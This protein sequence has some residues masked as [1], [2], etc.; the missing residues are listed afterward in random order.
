MRRKI[1]S[2]I[3]SRRS[4]SSL[5]IQNGPCTRRSSARC[6]RG[7]CKLASQAMP[8][9][10]AVFP[11][12]LTAVLSKSSCGLAASARQEPIDRPWR[13]RHER[14]HAGSLSCDA[15]ES[16]ACSY[17]CCRCRGVGWEGLEE[18]C[19][20]LVTSWQMP[21]VDQAH[22]GGVSSCATP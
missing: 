1:F 5:A 17:R 2:T 19:R 12:K 11:D 15:T 4:F 9:R 16:R 14:Q 6:H 22:A 13:K 21:P 7:D 3:T 18:C 10:P 20:R 8:C